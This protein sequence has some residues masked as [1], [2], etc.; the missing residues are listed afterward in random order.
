[1]DVHGVGRSWPFRIAVDVYQ[2]AYYLTARSFYGQRCGTPVD[3]G[4][5]FPNYRHDACHKVGAFD[6]SSGRDGSHVSSKGWHDAGDYGRYIVNSGVSTATLLWAIELWGKGS[7]R[8]I[9]LHVPESGNRTPDLLNEVR[10]N[11]D[12]MLTMQDADGGVWHKQTSAHFCG[13]VSPDKD[14]LPSLVIGAG[15][16]PFKTSCA[17]GDFAAVMAIAARVFLPYDRDYADRCLAAAKKAWQ[18][19]ATHEQILFRN[20]AGITTGEYADAR[21][22]DE[23]LWAAA[24]LVR[25]TGEL[26]FDA[27]FI[28]HY[29]EFLDGISVDDPP[30][31][32]NMSAFALW[33][34][35]LGGGRNEAAVQEI[36]SLSIA[37][38]AAIVQG[39]R[40]T[41]TAQA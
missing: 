25:T 26:P 17:S 24:E 31:N 33:T 21:C 8:N 10:W 39:P 9:S 7:I 34:Y 19:L 28:K 27:Y 4:P 3:L 32:S 35:A 13:F 5:E 38:A 16:T 30:N 6:P 41:R 12:W 1:L 29:R 18:W 22:T 15:K 40:A 2:R 36:K 23:Q 11:L 14:D 37:A 20:P